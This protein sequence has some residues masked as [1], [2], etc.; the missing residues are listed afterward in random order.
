MIGI[1]C[2]SLD[3]L[4]LCPP[5]I[6]PIDAGALRISSNIPASLLGNV[7]HD[8]L[9]RYVRT[10]STDFS[11]VAAALG[12]PDDQHD[13]ASI[14]VGYGI[15]AWEKLAHF[16]TA[17]QVESKITNAPPLMV[18]NQEYQ[19]L[20]TV[21]VASQAGT[22]KSIFIDWK[23]GYIDDGYANQMIGYAYCLWHWMGRPATVSITGVVVFLRHRYYRVI[24]YD[25]DMLATW[26]YDLTHNILSRPDQ[27]RPGQQCRFCD[28]HASCKARRAVMVST[29]D[30]IMGTST[31]KPGDTAWLDKATLSLTAM[32][33]DNKGDAS[34]G[35]LLVDVLFR[36]RLCE[37]AAENA[38]TLLR[39][40]VTRVGP[41]PLTEGLVLALRKIE[42]R[43]LESTKAMP[44]LQRHFS[45]TQ[46]AQASRISIGTLEQAFAA[47][48]PIGE[49]KASK[50]ELN[51]MLTEAGAV[52]V[53]TSY[54]LEQVQVDDQETDDDE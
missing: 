41:I 29:I 1:R 39:D 52:N 42:R 51:V 50:D 34:V 5:S 26:E 36:A 43:T 28:L 47:A 6:L 8:S 24:K 20:G 12:L 4:F 35:E 3:S 31:L 37:Q 38:K 16:F 7:C 11:T 21:D 45:T 18:K 53:T 48:K 25:A 46:I 17:P 49:K 2:S 13:D 14:L 19:V 23:S 9:A 44:V 27:Y 33:E 10:S 15:R 54:R 30:D 40:T 22:D 32:T